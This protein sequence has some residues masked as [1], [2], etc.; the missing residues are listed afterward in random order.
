M[1]LLPSQHSVNI[2]PPHTMK[3]SLRR[4]LAL[5]VFLGLFA[6]GRVQQT[7]TQEPTRVEIVLDEV[8][9]VSKN[10][11]TAVTLPPELR[12]EFKELSH[13][14][15]STST[16]ISASEFKRSTKIE[17]ELKDGEDDTTKILD[18]VQRALPDRAFSITVHGKKTTTTTTLS[19]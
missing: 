6:C 5:S 1:P 3:T 2:P 8:I 14:T 4:L 11:P 7:R 18:R 13:Y 15:V 19:M 17:F 9:D 12:N 10:S 16:T